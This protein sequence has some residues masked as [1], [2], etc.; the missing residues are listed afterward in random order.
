MIRVRRRLCMKWHRGHGC[1]LRWRIIVQKERRQGA[2]ALG[3]TILREYAV[4]SYDIQMLSANQS[5]GLTT[6]LT[7]EGY[8]LPKGAEQALQGYIK[9]GMKFFVAKVN[10]SRHNAA[11]MQELEPLQIR[12]RSENFMLPIQ[13][14]KVNGN[15]PQDLIVMTLTRNGMVDLANYSLKRVPTD[16]NL[17]IFVKDMF[18]DFYRAMFNKLAPKGGAY[19]EYAW[20]MAWC[21]PCADDPLSYDEFRQLGV[22]WVN[23]GNANTPNV[24]VTRMH[25]RYDHSNF[26]KDLMFKETD[27]RENFQGRYILNH[28][29]DGKITCEAGKE[30][31]AETRKRLKA[32]GVQLRALTSW[33]S[34]QISARIAKSVPA[35]YR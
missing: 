13:L 29:F 15:G 34:A 5:D 19:L 7:G 33:S 4:G 31:V 21:D 20:D 12:F 10:L 16:E 35:A 14:G 2:R 24:F 27:S 17:P 26:G 11:K 32:E 3:V 30:Y 18:P 22:S 9:M 8:K 1:R 23:R 25:I 6:Y 28:P